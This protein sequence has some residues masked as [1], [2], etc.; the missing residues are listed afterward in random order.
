MSST[1]VAT[2]PTA[3]DRR[4]Y[5]CHE[6]DMSI[7]LIPTS[8]TSSLCP[9]CNSD[10]LEELDSPI[11]FNTSSNPNPN[12][13]NNHDDS[14]QLLFPSFLDPSLPAADY[15]DGFH[16]PSVAP[17]DGIDNPYFHRV[18]NHLFNSDYHNP[19]AGA[20]TSRLHS[21]AAKSAIESIPTVKITTA[22]LEIDPV[23][24][25]AVCKDQFVIDDETKELPCKHMYHPDCIIP[26]LSQRNS[27]PVC[28]FQLPTDPVDG[29]S[30]VRRRSRSRVLR[31]G[32][33][34]DDDDDEELIGFGLRHLAR[35]HRLVFPMRHHQ[36]RRAGE[37]DA[38]ALFSPTQIGEEVQVDVLPDSGRTNSV[39]TVSS[40]PSWPVD[41]GK[42][43]DDV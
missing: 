22:F 28:R 29:D 36:S 12:P 2:T 3:M 38:E 34:V 30:K 27:C 24:I 10:F 21:P 5:W 15:A 37:V 7:S 25:C 8:S 39:E 23:V 20:T 31:L 19:S 35:R 43:E 40:W 41:G 6:C 18:I 11:I 26:W 16:F 42:F 32:D 33:L 9:H 14:N 17:S 4:T 1:T 13:S